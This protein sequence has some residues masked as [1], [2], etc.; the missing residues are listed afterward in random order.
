MTLG[1]SNGE[2]SALYFTGPHITYERFNN[3]TKSVCG[4]IYEKIK[5]RSLWRKYLLKQKCQTEKKCS[6]LNEF[7]IWSMKGKIKNLKMNVEELDEIIQFHIFCM[8]KKLN[9]RNLKE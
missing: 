8:N 9:K 4:N 7:D 3:M 2:K 6:E 5:M 1:G